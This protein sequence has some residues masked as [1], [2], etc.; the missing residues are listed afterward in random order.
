[1]APRGQTVREYIQENYPVYWPHGL[2]RKLAA[3]LGVT[4]QAVNQA[5]QALSLVKLEP[6]RVAIFCVDCTRDLGTVGGHEAKAQ[7]EI[8]LC[9]SC[10][11]RIHTRDDHFYYFPRPLGPYTFLCPECGTKRTLNERAQSTA[12][13]NVRR[14]I[15]DKEGWAPTCSR[16]CAITRGNRLAH[17]EKGSPRRQKAG[18]KVTAYWRRKRL[19]RLS[20][21]VVQ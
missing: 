5:V 3:E 4:H 7:E 9:T 20:Q 11:I 6:M 17:Y 1:M 13:N 19:A 21:N 14:V 10:M 16:T 2:N 15:V 12:E 18:R 8:Q